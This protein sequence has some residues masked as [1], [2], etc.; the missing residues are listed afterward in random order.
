MFIFSGKMRTKHKQMQKIVINGANGFVASH[1]IRELLKRNYEVVAFVRSGKK[2]SSRQKMTDALDEIN[3]DKSLNYNN[4][5]VFDYGLNS[6]D[7]TLEKE[8]IESIFN[9]NVQFF[10]FAACL[11]YGTKDRETIFKTNVDG[12]E[13]SIRFFEKYAQPG[14]RFFF[15]S[16]AYSCGKFSGLFEEKF[17]PNQDISHFRNYYEQSKR[18]A[19][20]VMKEQIERGK[21]NGHVIRLSQ[22]VGDSKTGVTKTGYGVFDLAKRLHGI[23]VKYPDQTLR[24]KVDPEGTQN[25][26]PIDRVV[27]TLIKMLKASDLPQIVNLT[28]KHDVKNEIIAQCIGKQLP[29]TI[30][31][32]KTLQQKNMN[33]LERMIAVGMSFTGKYARINLQF[34]H[35]NLDQIIRSDNNGVTK[36]SLCRMMESFIYELS[37]NK[38]SVKV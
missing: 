27:E 9:G 18:V 37:G 33:A 21:I 16:T 26:I 13:N 36:R 14:S 4:L 24:L 15:I 6:E 19:E 34:D 22:V 30:V 8:Q 25:L 17:Y 28:A 20:N 10:H 1:F 31:L 5:E 35:K 29:V 11:K 12:L 3:I 2:R 23:S 7:Y 32:D 38:T